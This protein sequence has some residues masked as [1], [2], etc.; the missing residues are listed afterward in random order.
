MAPGGLEERET[1]MGMSGIRSMMRCVFGPEGITRDG[2]RW[3]FQ[4]QLWDPALITDALVEERYQG[5]VEQPRRV[6]ET[7][8]VP[9]MAASL[10]ELAVPVF[11]LW[12]MSDQFCPPSGAST[13][14]LRCANA[15]V[16]TFTRCGHWVM[17][18]KR[19]VF[20][21]LCIDY[22]RHG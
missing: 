17:V 11:G 14:A 20:N 6:F 1:Y 8:N 2:V 16:T 9:N 5:A 10:P 4:K 13:L 12:G 7:M 21:R 22:L 3:V 18:E 19:D 15:R